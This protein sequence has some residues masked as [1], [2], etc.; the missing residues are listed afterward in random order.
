MG[1]NTNIIDVES[2][3]LSA[4]PS[5]APIPSAF[6]KL[7]AGGIVQNLVKKD[8]CSRPTPTYN[9]NYNPFEPLALIPAADYSPYA[10]GEP[11]FDDRLPI[12]S[13]FP[14]KH[15]L[16][17]ASKRGKQS[18]V[19]HIGYA[20]LDHTKPKTPTIWACKLCRVF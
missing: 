2:C 14:T 17:G 20:L 13:R 18:W 6:S 15:T 9:E 19:W 8:T 3:T 11:L 10:N 4:A 7:M 1:T 12:L 16:A 5:I